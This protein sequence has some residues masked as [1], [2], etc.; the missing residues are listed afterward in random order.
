MNNRISLRKVVAALVTVLVA[1]AW[2]AAGLNF[3]EVWQAYRDAQNV[4]AA[5]ELVDS[6]LQAGQ[7]VAYERGRTNVVLGAVGAVSPEDRD[8]LAMRRQEV[9][10]QIAELPLPVDG[11]VPAEDDVK[12]AWLHLRALRAEVDAAIA[13]PLQ[14]RD[15]AL[16]ERWFAEASSLIDALG[17]Q[18]AASS[19]RWENLTPAFRVFSRVKVTA[20]ALRDSEGAIASR[21][22]AGIASKEPISPADMEQIMRLRGLSDARWESLRREQTL[23]GT[24]SS[25]AQMKIIESD[26]FGGLRA[27]QGRVLAA[28]RTGAPYP[29][30]LPEMKEQAV[31]ALAAISRLLELES[32][33]TRAYADSHLQQCYTAVAWQGLVVL[34]SGVLGLATIIILVRGVFS[35]LS[36]LEGCLHAL[37]QGD[38]VAVG[39]TERWLPAEFGRLNIAAQA[40]RDALVQKQQMADELRETSER[41]SSILDHHPGT[42]VRFRY[43]QGAPR[44]IIFSAGNSL[45]L[46]ESH[47]LQLDESQDLYHPDDRDLVNVRTPQILREK[48]ETVI[49]FRRRRLDGSWTW[50]RAWERVVEHDGDDMITEAV[51]FN[52]SEEMLAKEALERSSTELRQASQR[53]AG[54]VSSLPGVVFTASIRGA[55]R[56]ITFLSDGFERYCGMPSAE[57]LAMPY[58]EQF[59]FLHPDDREGFLHRWD[60]ASPREVCISRARF[61]RRDGDVRWFE[62]HER[63]TS[64]DDQG[65]SVGGVAQ[66]ITD[67]VMAEQALE[68]SEATRR[69]MEERLLES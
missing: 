68:R 11:Q 15:P 50:L 27:M 1:T 5:N 36:A 42:V 4:L 47:L 51:T 16:V 57:F 19:L 59:K 52:V 7:S 39:V 45:I 17:Q 58:A 34:L 28:S 65:F 60:K 22:S 30:S 20:L 12:D 21:I 25:S 64:A 49:T 55:D 54:L 40:F 69:K 13:G 41:L 67:K 62:F 63:V 23:V 10:R 66:D 2:T 32:A 46:R 24:A 18:A 53:L 48:G 35:P 3:V 9:D 33:N 29:V 14:N 26:L 44:E 38:T 56:K 37:A 31:G 8:Y 6:L 61:V 43:R